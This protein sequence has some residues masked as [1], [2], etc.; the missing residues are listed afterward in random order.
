[1]RGDLA[2][3]L[4]DDEL[5]LIAGSARRGEDD[6][7]ELVLLIEEEVLDLLVDE[8]VHDELLFEVAP[9]LVEEAKLLVSQR[10]EQVVTLKVPLKAEPSVGDNWLDATISSKNT[11]P[12][13]KC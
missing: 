12:W 7:D 4:L 9:E 6:E 8:Q 10:M 13:R 1:M 3:E 5:D 11:P 2:A